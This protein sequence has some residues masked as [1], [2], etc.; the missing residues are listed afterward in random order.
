MISAISKQTFHSRINCF[1][2]ASVVIQF[3]LRTTG[4]NVCSSKLFVFQ[5]FSLAR[6]QFPTIVYYANIITSG[7]DPRRI[8]FAVLV[9]PFDAIQSASVDLNRLRRFIFYKN[10]D[11]R[12]LLNKHKRSDNLVFRSSRIN[13]LRNKLSTYT[14]N[15]LEK[16]TCTVLT[17]IVVREMLLKLL[18]KRLMM[19]HGLLR[20]RDMAQLMCWLRVRY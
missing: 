18:L 6:I 4:F 20:Y 14:Q 16:K 10:I 9:R 8:R 15:R 12:D 19:R 17:H 3:S 2:Q 13:R 5:Q 1:C 11:L 7:G